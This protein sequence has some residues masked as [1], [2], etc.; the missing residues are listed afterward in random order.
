SRAEGLEDG[1][2]ED[3]GADG[4]L[5]VEAEDD[6]Q[7]RRHQAAAAHAG[8]PDENPDEQPRERELPRHALAPG[9]GQETKGRPV[10]RHPSLYA[11]HRGQRP[12]TGAISASAATIEPSPPPARSA[13]SA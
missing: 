9:I 3:V 10:S 13:P 2:V 12:V 8:H 4:D 7:D 11:S 6:D 1:A 5:R